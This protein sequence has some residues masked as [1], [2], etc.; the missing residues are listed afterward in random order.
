MKIC[1]HSHANENL[2][3]YKKMSTRACFE[4]E[5]KRNL[6][7]AYSC[8]VF[9]QRVMQSPEPMALTIV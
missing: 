9:F 5:A 4:K 1:F 3:L 2:F 6:E 7:M 8:F